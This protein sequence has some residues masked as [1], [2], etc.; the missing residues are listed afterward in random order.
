MPDIN[1]FQGIL[2]Q[3]TCAYQWG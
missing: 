3:E 1:Y 2:G